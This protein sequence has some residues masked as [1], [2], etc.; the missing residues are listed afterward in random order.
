[1]RQTLCS[2][3]RNFSDKTEGHVGGLQNLP[4]RLNLGRI[5]IWEILYPKLDIE[6]VGALASYPMLHE[7]A[8]DQI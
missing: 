6:P 3:Q 2:G 1:M 5:A 8:A 4:N 7:N